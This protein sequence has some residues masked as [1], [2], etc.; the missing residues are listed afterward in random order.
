M[1]LHEAIKM[2]LKDKGH[3][4]PAKE[5]AY[6]INLNNMYERGDKT[7]VPAGQ[8]HARVRRYPLLFKKDSLGK[9]VLI[10]E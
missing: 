6:L 4:L 1:K 7:P 9:I 3:S 5:I 8:I 2:V 10:D